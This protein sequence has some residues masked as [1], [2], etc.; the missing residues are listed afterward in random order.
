MPG[1]GILCAPL[2]HAQTTINP[3]ISLI[4]DIRAVAHTDAARPDER[5]NVNLDLS[6]A[7]IAIQGYL[8]PYARAD[9]YF[10]W[11]EGVNAEVEELYFTISRGIPF[12][13]SLRG[14]RYLLLFDKVNPL[15]P[16]AYSFIHRPLMHEEFFGEEGL[17]DVGVR[18]SML[19]P[20]GNVA[21][22]ISIDVLKNDWLSP[23]EHGEGDA[24]DHETDEV[25]DDEVPS[26]R[27]FLGRVE[28]F[29]PIT[30]LTSLSI[31][32]SA[33]TGVPTDD[34]RR[35]VV[36]ADA[37]LRWKPD[38]YQS[39]TAVAE[40]MVNHAPANNA[41]EHVAAGASQ[42]HDSESVTSHGLFGYFDY[43]F[44]ERYNVGALGDWTQHADDSDHDRWRLGGFAGFA[45][46]GETTLLR[47]LVDYTR[48]DAVVEGFWTA[49]LQLVFSLGPHRPHTF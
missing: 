47:L 12:G 22:E 9:A 36:G 38:R 32:V 21:A 40:W 7:E 13:I 31:G 44:R 48:D 20:V 37:K 41:F 11:H 30:E 10:G 45:P 6:G 49:T 29:V 35:T 26:E 5:D 8:N 39:F 24:H 46:V 43:Q 3:D 15:H 19:V 17:R 42:D 16:H 2:A 33:L 1:I 18:A 4:G 27:S 23:H 14:G 25:A 28:S 34:E